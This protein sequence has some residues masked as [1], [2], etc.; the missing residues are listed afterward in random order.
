[1]LLTVLAVVQVL[2]IRRESQTWDEAFEIASGYRY[3]FTGDYRI[4]L[5]QP[6]LGRI[7]SAL[8]LLFLHLR[9][10]VDQPS[11]HE[12]KEVEFGREF[13]YHNRVAAGVIL[14]WAR[15]PTIAVTLCLGLALAGWTRA[16]F[17]AAAGLLALAAFSFDPN[18]IAY[19]RYAKN[20]MLAALMSFLACTA[21]AAYLVRGKRS[22]LWLT[23][24]WL[25]LAVASKFS[26]GFLLP[27]FLILA[28]ARHRFQHGSLR[29]WAPALARVFAIA[30]VVTLLV[31]APQ[32]QLLV[33]V[34]RATR[35]ADP[36]MHMLRDTVDA[37]TTTGWILRWMGSHLG[38]R[39]HPLL[40]G[41]SQV[42]QHNFLGHP[43]YL[44]G[45]FSD[46]GW[47]Y[48]FPVAWAVKTPLATLAAAGVALAAALWKRQGAGFTHL[49]L[50]VP[51]AVFVGMSMITHIDIGLRHLLPI[52]PFLF[53]LLGAAM[54]QWRWPY[55]AAACLLIAAESLAVYPNY[56]AFF[57]AAVGGPANGP[58]Y[59]LDS[60]IDWGQDLIKLK[61]WMDARGVKQ[62]CIAYFGSA[63]WSYYGV[64]GPPVQPDGTGPETDCY[65]AVSVTLLYGLYVGPERY[66]WLR[67][68]NP[69]AR[70]GYSIYVYDLRAHGK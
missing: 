69:V 27:V 31:Y 42:A 1:M 9:A 15:V 2:S 44:L 21:W 16:Q 20:D 64:D 58:H 19:G 38:L 40:V 46:R 43:A 65:A 11:W 23:G 51:I 45:M 7:L 67:S 68:R 13:L 4:S 57:N 29:D 6:P 5:E 14:F 33:P 35:L 59:L 25:G 61:S 34:T 39:A 48:Y 24:I 55:A 60:N 49:V 17:G 36:T 18:V 37:R 70:I 12:P 63:D 41:L 54:S 3:L 56:L 22:A 50:L 53:A 32:T 47:W 28:L 10:P 26:A 8:P 30:C 52:F 66:A 62:V